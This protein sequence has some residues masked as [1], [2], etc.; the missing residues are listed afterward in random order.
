MKRILLAGLFLASAA[1]ITSYAIAQA[2]PCCAPTAA[3]FPKVG[4]NY[5][6]WNYS[7]LNKITTANVARLGGAWHVDVDA[8]SAPA[9]AVTAAALS[10]GGDEGL[11][12]PGR[13]GRGGGGGGGG[14]AGQ[15]SSAVVVGGVLYIENSTGRVMAVD[16]KTGQVKWTYNSGYGNQLRRGVAV[17]GGKVFTAGAGKHIVALDQNTG[18]VVWDKQLDVNDGTGG[19]LKTAITYFDGMI[20]FGNAD[21]QRGTG[22]AFN[23]DTGAEVWRFYGPASPEEAGKDT[24]GGDQWKTGGA[25]PWVHPAIDPQLGLVYWTFGNARGGAPTDGSGR[26]GQNLYAN[27]LVALNAKTGKL[28]WYFQSVHHDIWDM[29]NVMAPVL[30][31]VMVEGRLRKIVVYGSKTG[32]YY[33]LDRT[34]G[35]AVTPIDEKPM[36]QEP[37]Q[38][39]WPTQPI[40]RGDS[41]LPICANADKTN[42]V[43]PN[44][45][46]GCLYEP[47]LDFPVVQ[48]PGTGGGMTWNALSFDPNTGL[49][50]TG[51][52]IVNSG[53]VQHNGGVGFRPL[54]EERSGKV[55]AFNPATHKVAW[56][57][58]T[59]WS[60]AHGNGIL[61]TAGN[62]MFIGQPDGQLVA[63][64]IKDGKEL[65]KFQ[66]GAGVHTSPVTYEIDGEQYVAVFAGGNGLPYNSP[67]GDELWAFKIGGT[68]PQ[69]PTPAPPP[70]RQPITAT[71]VEGSAAGNTVTLARIWANGAVGTE[72]SNAE[73]AMAPQHLRVPAGT[74]VTFNN[75]ASN[76]QT[77]CAS[78]FFE[79]LFDKKLAPGE[80][81]TF[82]FTKPGEYFYN[83]CASPRTTGKVVVY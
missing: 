60:L 57:K 62:V 76:K 4:G 69:A 66:T 15:Q 83:D 80:S 26:P 51:V 38:K 18:A 65:W 49:I 59:V 50:Y 17:G 33:V 46:F 52:G 67:R 11:P 73:A 75:P 55:V 37:I 13:G 82:T 35:T 6:N 34:N 58:D 43:P 47:H 8:G 72:E 61:T 1:A 64:D 9:P 77:H 23:A 19:S 14:A 28:A 5:G 10:A 39:T 41:V 78:Q 63:M 3:D 24:W 30:A 21:A 29:D 81:F 2:P 32:M 54:G 22:Y 53:H 36:P 7:S 68:V 45:K 40:P 44:Y 31:D 70:I 12:A 16:G 27:S 74:T 48:S 79:G 25:S 20:Y 42:R 56:S 71:A